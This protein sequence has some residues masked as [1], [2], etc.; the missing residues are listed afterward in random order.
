M[1]ITLY[2]Y[3][4]TLIFEQTYILDNKLTKLNHNYSIKLCSFTSYNTSLFFKEK[5]FKQESALYN[6]INTKYK[7]IDKSIS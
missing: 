1:K 3:I 5:L 2:N 6:A 7:H 4:C